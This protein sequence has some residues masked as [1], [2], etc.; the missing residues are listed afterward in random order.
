MA[1]ITATEPD[2]TADHDDERRGWARLWQPAY[3]PPVLVGLAIM[4]LLV[5]SGMEMVA[6]YAPTILS[7]SGFGGRTFAFAVML[8]LSVVNLTMILVSATIIDRTGR[9]PLLISGLVVMTA[10]LVSFAVLYSVDH[11]SAWARWSEIGCL[12]VL[13]ATFWLSV[14]MVGEIVIHEM[15][16]L[17]IRGPAASLSYGMYS[18]FL[19]M[20]TLTFPLLLENIG[21][22]VIVLS[23]AVFNIAGALYLLGALPETKGKSLEDI[24][25]YWRHRAVPS[26]T[27]G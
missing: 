4:L 19:I 6:F 1:L 25:D 24:G 23:Y 12:V 13:G 15:Y 7:D 27:H 20:F 21:L 14:G 5:F 16:P 10:C 18:V 26:E 8:G 3:R 17:S 22:P 9:K 11:V 2:A